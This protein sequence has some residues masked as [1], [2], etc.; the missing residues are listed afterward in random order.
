MLDV[1]MEAAAELL[2]VALY[3]LAAGALTT[4]GVLAELSSLSEYG[5]GHT[6]AALWLAFVGAVALYAGVYQLGYRTLLGRVVAAV[7]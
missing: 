4:L 6:T 1:A 5:A 7:R 2:S 3:A